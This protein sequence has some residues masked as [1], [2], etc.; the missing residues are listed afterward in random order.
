MQSG[1]A[2][3]PS[4]DIATDETLLAV[5]DA[6]ERN[7]LITQRSVAR[8][9]NIALGLANAYLRRCARKGLIKVSAVPA[10]RYAYYLTPQGFAE[11]SRL[12]ADYLADSF[13][14]FRQARSQ[15]ADAFATAAACGQRRLLLI[16]V[17]ELA[18]I[19]SLVVRNHAVEIV[20]VIAAT[21]DEAKLRKTVGSF[22]RIDGAVLTA[23]NGAPE[24]YKAAIAVFGT[25]RVHAP[26]LLRLRPQ[27]SI[28]EVHAS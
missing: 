1:D 6:I 26:A 12:T 24:A 15:C 16:G 5:L 2:E 22:N 20:A 23:L 25:E 4:G 21:G 14:F 9:L 13:S 27:Q 10:R 28:S 7:P 17:G 8:E 19:A 18:E 11:K 3:I